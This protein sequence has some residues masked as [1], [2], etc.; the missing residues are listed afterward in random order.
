MATAQR[1]ETKSEHRRQS[2]TGL[3]YDA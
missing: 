1:V 3:D 2:S